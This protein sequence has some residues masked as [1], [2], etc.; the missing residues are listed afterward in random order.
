MW[1]GLRQ[2]EWHT[3]KPSLA[4]LAW[5][6]L[7]FALAQFNLLLCPSPH[8]E[9]GIFLNSLTLLARTVLYCPGLIR[10]VALF[11]T[12]GEGG[13]KEWQTLKYSLAFLARTVLYCPNPS[14]LALC[15]SEEPR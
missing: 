12:C 14:L 10:L 8:S 3:L 9:N 13:G 6:V 4:S 15:P 7:F 11:H 5:T 1:N 2:G